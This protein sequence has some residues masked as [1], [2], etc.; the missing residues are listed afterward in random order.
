MQSSAEN[1]PKP[2]S[3][4]LDSKFGK[5]VTEKVQPVAGD[6]LDVIGDVTGIEAIEKIGELL[7]NKKT[8]NGPARRLAEEFEKFKMEWQLELNR[9]EISSAIELLK[10]EF[11]DKDSARKRETGFMSLTGG[12]DWLMGAVVI[13]GLALLVLTVV[14]LVYVE[15]PKE[16]Q[17]LADMCFG[18]VMSIGASIFSYY[19]GSTKGS[20]TKDETIK[21][22]VNAK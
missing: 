18:A 2:F 3:K 20:H 11:L 12:R 22:I 5:F 1:K 21:K 4:F 16:N 19:I 9:L 7:N 15:I 17:R 6:V 8:D 13:T 14:T 10:T